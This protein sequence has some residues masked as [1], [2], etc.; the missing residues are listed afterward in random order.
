MHRQLLDGIHWVGALDW[1]VR[2]FHSYH[3]DRG[4][5]YNAYLI[6][7]ESN[8]LIDAVKAPFKASLLRNIRELVDPASIRYL[9]CNHAEPDHASALPDVL[10]ALPNATIVCNEKC[11]GILAAYHD[12]TDWPFQIVETGETLSLGRRTLSFLNTPMVHWP[13]SMMTYVQEEK[14]LFS[15]DAF[16]QHWCTSQRFDD[17]VDLR[18]LLLEAKTYYANI[19]MPYGKQVAKTLEAAS[20]LAIEVIAPSHGLIWR[21]HVAEIVECYQAWAVCK[22]TA[23][24]LVLYDTM[25]ENTRRM[26]E[27]IAEGATREGV[28]VLS[29]FVRANTGTR[30]ATEIL[31]AACVAVGS[32]TLNQQMMPAMAGILNYVKGL[33]P[34]GKAG[35]AFG[36]YGWGRG[37]AEAVQEELEAM[38]VETLADPLRSKWCSTSEEMTACTDAGRMLAEKALAIAAAAS[39]T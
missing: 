25:W 3:T 21:S 22:P 38:G 16:G 12:T 37:G 8:A 13:D 29:L 4:A 27:A 5:T 14:L 34:A 17:E 2:D 20:G 32:S 30:V 19:V 28:E 7:D 26:A 6:Q 31:D 23:K 35:L 33:R 9:I 36:S 24:V 39:A 10:A 1:N 15:M 18:Q 11:R